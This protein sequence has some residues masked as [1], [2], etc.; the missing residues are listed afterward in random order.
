MEDEAEDARRMDDETEGGGADESGELEAA[1]AIQ[2]SYRSHRYKCAASGLSLRHPSTFSEEER[3]AIR[4]EA[5]TAPAAMEAAED[6]EAILEVENDN[7]NDEKRA[8][9]SAAA[10][11][12]T[13]SPARQRNLELPDFRSRSWRRAVVHRAAQ[14]GA[15][16]SGQKYS[17]KAGSLVDKHWLE[18]V[19]KKH[20]HGANLAPYYRYWRDNSGTRAPFFQ[21]LD[22][23]DGRKL[24]LYD[25]DYGVVS[26]AE[27][28]RE[29]ITYLTLAQRRHYEVV[30]EP[31]SGRLVYVESGEPVDTFAAACA[32]APAPSA[33]RSSTLHPHHDSDDFPSPPPSHDASQPPEPLPRWIFVLSAAGKLYVGQKTTCPPR[34]QHSSFLSG[35][36]AIAAGRLVVDRGKVLVIQAHS[37]HY[38]FGVDRTDDFVSW[39]RRR[40]ADLADLAVEYHKASKAPRSPNLARPPSISR[41]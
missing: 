41:A 9:E 17:V 2:R 10:E 13:A 3:R 11:T 7:E 1:R 36:A 40:G 16:L 25:P 15:G 5:W 14:V 6:A 23:G 19:D 30:V 12:S 27:M 26:R 24:D 34:F 35:G 22:E 39:L 4:D 8:R 32:A 31:H 38:R 37:G 21:W 20:R 29:V 28:E 33:G 18:A